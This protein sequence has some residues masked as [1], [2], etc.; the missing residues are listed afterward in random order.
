MQKQKIV[1]YSC[2]P[3]TKENMK[4]EKIKTLDTLLLGL[5]TLYSTTWVP[6]ATTELPS[7]YKFI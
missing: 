6:L 3:I 7:N 4:G 1:I 2:T 5:Q